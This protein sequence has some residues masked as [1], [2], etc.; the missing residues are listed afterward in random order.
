MGLAAILGG[1]H[2]L[3]QRLGVPAY[4]VAVFII[5]GSG[6]VLARILYVPA[7]A[8]FRV[9]NINLKG[10]RALAERLQSLATHPTPAHGKTAGLVPPAGL[11]FLAEIG[12]LPARP[13]SRWLR[14]LQREHT[15]TN[16]PT[17]VEEGT[18]VR[19]PSLSGRRSFLRRELPADVIR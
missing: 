16:K 18:A 2:G 13:P 15:P 3:L 9:L 19:A 10:L 1:S 8:I 17:T 5:V 12:S 4:D 11:V 14:Q 6:W 7:Y